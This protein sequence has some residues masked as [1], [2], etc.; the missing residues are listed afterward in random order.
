VL[1]GE[2]KIANMRI[3]RS[4]DPKEFILIRDMKKDDKLM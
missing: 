3:C 1:F 2:Y 4:E